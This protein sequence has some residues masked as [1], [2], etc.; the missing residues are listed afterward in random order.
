MQL[1][2][3]IKSIALVFGCLCPALWGLVSAY[4]YGTASLSFYQV[5]NRLTQWRTQE[6]QHCEAE[7]ILAKNEMMSALDKQPNHPLYADT[8]AQI[9]EWGAILGYEN[10]QQALGLAIQYY[11]QATQLRP[12]WPVSWASLSMVKWRL[13]EFDDEML[14]YLTNADKF[15]PFKPEVHILFSQL[16]L[17]LYRNNHPLLINIRPEF[18]RHLALGIR[19]PSSRQVVINTINNSGLSKQV[20]RWLRHEESTILKLYECRRQKR[21]AEQLI[22]KPTPKS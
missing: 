16:G 11:L 12:A 15:G 13:Q 6:S 21:K 19:N 4:Q 8:M 10:S 7:Y 3:K 2:K 9:Y 20:C 5:N 22:I 1:I 18:E 14:G 17:A